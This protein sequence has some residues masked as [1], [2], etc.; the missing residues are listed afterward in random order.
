[1]NRRALIA[2]VAVGIAGLACDLDRSVR[3]FPPGTVSMIVEDGTA[4]ACSVAGEGEPALVLVHGWAC[5]RAYWKHQVGH[6]AATNRVVAIDLAGHGDSGL[7]RQVWTLDALARDV[8]AVLEAESLHRVIL[9]GHSLG[10]PV[11]LL[12]ARR[13]PDRVIGIVAV[14]ALHDV[15]QPHRDATLGFVASLEADFAGTLRAGVPGLFGQDADPALV[16]S[17]AADMAAA[18]PGLSIALE[19][20]YAGMDLGG[21]MQALTVPIRAIN[22]SPTN[23]EGNRRH[24]RDFDARLMENA[25]HFPMLERPDEFNAL[26]ARAIAEIVA[27]AGALA[28]PGGRSASPGKGPGP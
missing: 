26:L 19:R 10:A 16:E 6:F 24:A 13:A 27:P 14:D 21:A 4:I 15:E 17:I 9:V 23:A 20:D 3:R 5:D 22:A 1:M 12:A 2:V 28:Q 11:A 18:P 8:V 25:G 7:G